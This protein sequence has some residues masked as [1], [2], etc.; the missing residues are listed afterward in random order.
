ME[1]VIQS[2]E[3]N[4][5]FA[6]V[7]QARFNSKRFPGKVLQKV[8]GREVLS[9]LIERLEKSG[10]KQSII[11]ATTTDDSDDKIAKLGELHGIKVFRGSEDDVLKRFVD[12]LETDDSE[13]IVR[14]TADCPF[15]DPELILKTIKKLE[16]EKK[17]Y[18]SNCYPP[19]F[20]DGLDVEAFTKNSLLEA[21]KNSYSNPD[22]EHVTKW[23]RDNKKANIGAII[24]PIDF[25]KIRLT[26][27]YP[28]DLIVIKKVISNF[29]NNIYFNWDQLSEFIQSNESNFIHNSNF[30]RNEGSKISTGQKLWGR[31]TRVIPGGNMLLSKRPDMFLPNKWP[32]YFSKAKGCKIWDLDGKDYIDTSIM[33]IGTNILGYG[34][35]AVDNAVKEAIDKSNMSTFNCPEEVLLAEKLISIHNWADM[36]RFARSG[37]EAN[38]IAIRIARAASGKEKIAICGYHGWHDW[39]LATN[40]GNNSALKEHLLPG[41]DPAGV[42]P[43]LQGTVFPFCY[44][45]FAELKSIVD[46]NDIGAIK[47]EVERNT[48]PEKNFLKKVRELCDEKGIIL[49][50]DECTSGFRE[51]YGGLH[52]K[53]NVEP[54]MAMFGKAI[55]NGFALT[56]IIGKEEIMQSCQNTFISSTFWTERIGFVAALKTLEV[57]ESI[58][59]WDI[60]SA[61]G[62]KIKEGWK[63]IS[64]KYSI[65]L[66]IFGLDALPTFAFK[67]ED[68][69]K[70]KTLITQEML[71]K[72]FLAGNSCYVCIEHNDEIIDA[73]LSNLDEIFNVISKCIDNPQLIDE[74]LETEVCTS[75][76]KRLN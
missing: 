39:Y 36:A 40:L 59:S 58:N 38:A 57:M 32:T 68:N 49:I 10:L 46:Q 9:I 41:L 74:K 31:A 61:Q 52:K 2:F 21:D 14:L 6:I 34:N 7:I 13:V 35:K 26:L 70:F 60:I 23:I 25:S 27:D 15:V 51:T 69:L 75:G 73:Y 17:D 33:G 55:G 53:Y 72:G 24:N 66:D 56:A 65:N 28:E 37:G 47:M 63:K 71:K 30:V 5:K 16:N 67:H 1:N 22:R 44:N 29:K 18:V 8:Y 62:N 48:P 12:A 45:N 4:S 50:F 11:L 64:N 20:P 43:Q 3:I 76:F 19:T 42:P 54:D